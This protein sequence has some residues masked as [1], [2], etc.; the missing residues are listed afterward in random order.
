MLGEYSAYQFRSWAEPGSLSLG[1]CEKTKM[2]RIWNQMHMAV[3]LCKSAG[4]R[5]DH[6]TRVLLRRLLRE[7]QPIAA[8]Q[9]I[10][11]FARDSTSMPLIIHPLDVHQ[12]L[13]KLFVCNPRGCGWGIYNKI[14]EICKMII[15]II[16]FNKYLMKM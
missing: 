3:A 7:S 6:F 15:C 4:E 5:R 13:T 8:G 12:Y 14:W 16:F 11:L 9:L 10:T 1:R 2:P